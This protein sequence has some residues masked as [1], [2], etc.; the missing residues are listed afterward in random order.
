MSV[1]VGP[2]LAVAISLAGALGFIGPG[3]KTPDMKDSLVEASSILHA[4]SSTNISIPNILPIQ[5]GTVVEARGLL[6]STD[7]PDVVDGMGLPSLFLEMADV[8][9]GSGIPLL[10]AGS[11]ADGRGVAAAICLGAEN[12][13]EIVRAGEGVVSTTRTLLYN[14]LR[15][16]YGWS[17]EQAG[18]LEG[19]AWGPEGRRGQ[20]V[21][22]SIGLIHDIKGS[23]DIVRGVREEAVGILDSRR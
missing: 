19:L 4:A 17:E 2:K 3:P 14:H 9:A 5:I 15:R 6:E 10:P 21:G 20:Y 7:K 16:E 22:A 8:M 12:V 1:L 23:R 18:D 13:N 11:I